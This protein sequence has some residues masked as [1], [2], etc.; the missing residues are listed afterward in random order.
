MWMEFYSICRVFNIHNKFN[1]ISMNSL[2]CGAFKLL[3]PATSNNNFPT[4]IHICN[5][6]KQKISINMF[7]KQRK[8]QNHFSKR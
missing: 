6:T 8:Q 2:I 5:K 1:Q 3:H 4:F 7:K